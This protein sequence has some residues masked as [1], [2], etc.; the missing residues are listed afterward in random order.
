[1]LLIEIAHAF[2]KSAPR[3]FDDRVLFL[4]V[5]GERREQGKGG[6]RDSGHQCAKSHGILDV[7]PGMLPPLIV[8]G[9]RRIDQKGTSRTMA[10]PALGAGAGFL[11]A[12]LG[13]GAAGA[14]AGGLRAAATFG[15]GG[16]SLRG[17][18]AGFALAA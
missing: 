10:P 11:A 9:V 17:A 13:A 1:M 7:P 14:G 4:G 8:G 5:S 6:D 3:H 16:S 12:G 18:G 15:A 2:L